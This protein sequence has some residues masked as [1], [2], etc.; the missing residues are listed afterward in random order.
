MLYGQAHACMAKLMP[1][2]NWEKYSEIFIGEVSGV[3]LIGYEKDRLKSLS[4]GDNQRWFTDVT[5]TQ[6]LNLL[7][8][9]VF[10]GKPKPLLDV[11][12]G[13][14]GVVTPRP[15]MFGIFFVSKETG[16]IIPIYETEG[17]LYYELLVKLGKMSR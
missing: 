14:C 1:D 10:V 4:R 8:T 11:K 2:E 9:K 15:M 17:E 13:G 6:N 3:H 5:Q 7:V 12:V 16:A